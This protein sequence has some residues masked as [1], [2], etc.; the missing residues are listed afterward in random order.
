MRSF[1]KLPV[2]VARSNNPDHLPKQ[3]GSHQFRF[4]SAQQKAKRQKDADELER[5][6]IAQEENL[7]ERD[8]LLNR[9]QII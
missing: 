5:Q 7:R 1:P 3:S 9:A 8:R 4:A 6:K 2:F